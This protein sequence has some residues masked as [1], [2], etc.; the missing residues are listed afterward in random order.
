MGGLPSAPTSPAPSAP[1]SQPPSPPGSPRVVTD[2]NRQPD[3]SQSMPFPPAITIHTR[4]IAS[5][6]V[7]RPDRV[8]IQH[9]QQSVL[10]SGTFNSYIVFKPDDLVIKPNGYVAIELSDAA[11][12]P[13]IARSLSDHRHKLFNHVTISYQCEWG[14]WPSFWRFKINVKSMMA[15]PVQVR[16]LPSHERWLVDE[17]C[18]FHEW[19]MLVRVHLTNTGTE[20]PGRGQ[21]RFHLTFQAYDHDAF[22]STS[23]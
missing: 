12:I 22:S 7:G 23:P 19:L 11:S 20:P 4:A 8:P 5:D 1:N 3:A 10:A 16:W 9:W 2:Y 15:I 17:N 18:E 14:D 6:P 13:E 21:H